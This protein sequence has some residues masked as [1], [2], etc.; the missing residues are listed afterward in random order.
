MVGGSQTIFGDAAEW[1]LLVGGSWTVFRDAAK[2]FP[3]VGGSQTI[4]PQ[5]KD[6]SMQ[7]RD[8]LIPDQP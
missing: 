8:F 1:F 5:V 3:L 6:P 4:F 2:W 7:S